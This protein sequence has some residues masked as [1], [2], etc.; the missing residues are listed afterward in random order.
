MIIR[1]TLPTQKY[2]KVDRKVFGNKNFSDGAVR[3]YGFLCGLRNGANFSDEYLMKALGWSKMV[4]Y[5]KKKELIQGDLLLVDRVGAKMYVGYIGFS[6][7][8]AS[9]VKTHWLDNEDAGS[10][11]EK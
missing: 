8:P 6:D 1:H 5:R 3:L 2:T 7:F 9:R 11:G 4:L 10:L